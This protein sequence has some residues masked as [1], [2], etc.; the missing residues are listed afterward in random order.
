MRVMTTL[1]HLPKAHQANKVIEVV[2][3]L[4]ME[5]LGKEAVVDSLGW[6]YCYYC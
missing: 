1:T 5:H 3:A 2:V 4:T 6:L